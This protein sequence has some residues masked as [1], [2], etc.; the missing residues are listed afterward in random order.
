MVMIVSFLARMFNR[1]V[2]GQMQRAERDIS[3]YRHLLPHD[4]QHFGDTLIDRDEKSL[5]FGR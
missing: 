3:R 5:P 4:L 1:F 2:E